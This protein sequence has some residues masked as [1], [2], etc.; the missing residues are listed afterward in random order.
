MRKRY[1]NLGY[2]T[3]LTKLTRLIKDNG[4]P[5]HQSKSNLHLSKRGD[6][7]LEKRRF[8]ELEIDNPKYLNLSAAYLK[9]K[10]VQ[11]IF[12]AKKLMGRSSLLPRF[13]L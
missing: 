13:S 1:K 10:K 8:I 12:L 5:A 3:I 4:R 2:A 7:F 6:T 11:G 9:G